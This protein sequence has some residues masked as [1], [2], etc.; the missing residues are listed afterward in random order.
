MEFNGI[1]CSYRMR[2]CNSLPARKL[3]W[4]LKLENSPSFSENPMTAA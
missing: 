4:L 2:L 1:L 3:A